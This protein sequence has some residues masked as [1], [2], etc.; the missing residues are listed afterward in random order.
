[1]ECAPQQPIEHK[2][3]AL[4]RKYDAA[5]Q[6]QADLY[7]SDNELEKWL[8]T[9]G[10]L[11]AGRIELLRNFQTHTKNAAT[12]EERAA[13]TTVT[14]QLMLNSS[15]T[16]SHVSKVGAALLRALQDTNQLGMLPKAASGANGTPAAKTAKS[17][18]KTTAAK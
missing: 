12:D 2:P 8:H 7:Q 11:E 10:V 14:N 5:M 18:K 16:L 13:F 15:C 6:K 1:M 4:K 3:S 9:S 17:S